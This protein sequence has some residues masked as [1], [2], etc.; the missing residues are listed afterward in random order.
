MGIKKNS[1]RRYFFKQQNGM[2]YYGYWD[3]TNRSTKHP[4]YPTIEDD[5]EYILNHS[6]QCIVCISDAEILQK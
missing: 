4:I 2:E 6:E 5:Y 1:N 3:S